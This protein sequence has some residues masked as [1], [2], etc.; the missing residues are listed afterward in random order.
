[1]SFCVFKSRFTNFTPI[2]APFTVFT[3]AIHLTIL[4]GVFA[5]KRSRIVSSGSSCSPVS[6]INCI[7]V[8]DKFNILI[9]VPPEGSFL[10]KQFPVNK[11]ALRMNPL[12]SKIN[13][14]VIP[15]IHLISKFR[16]MP[17]S[18]KATRLPLLQEGHI[19]SAF[20]FLDAYT[21]TWSVFVPV[22]MPT[23]SYLG[24]AFFAGAPG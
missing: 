15:Q 13:G 23:T 21:F 24:A 19:T 8:V 2:L 20:F 4:V 1:M 18:G 14:I 9:F 17:V 3:K 7:P 22:L 12:L 16:G 11:T 6:L 5:W 10:E